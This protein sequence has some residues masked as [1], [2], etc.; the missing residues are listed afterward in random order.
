MCQVAGLW[1][2][3][4]ALSQDFGTVLYRIQLLGFNAIR[5]PFSFQASHCPATMHRG[6]FWHKTPALLQNTSAACQT[7]RDPAVV[8]S[9]AYSRQCSPIEPFSCTGLS[10]L[11]LCASPVAARHRMAHHCLMCYS[12]L[13]HGCSELHCYTASSE[14]A[15]PC[16]GALQYG[17]NLLHCHLHTCHC[18]ASGPERDPPR[19]KHLH[20]HRSACSG[21]IYAPMRDECR[22]AISPE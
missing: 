12:G 21:D 8:G 7:A 2:G 3:P 1:Q 22:H 17:T 4:T 20:D 15:T 16:A 13:D 5:L 11:S 14:T 6:Q 19:H 18:R 9:A 10:A